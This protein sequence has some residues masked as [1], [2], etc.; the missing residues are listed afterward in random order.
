MRGEI[1]DNQNHSKQ[2]LSEKEKRRFDYFFLEALKL[3]QT[4][5]YSD[6]FNTFQYCLSIDSTSAAT[7]YELSFFYN[8]L[9]NKKL[10]L[11]AL[12]KA[13]Q[14]GGNR[15]DY[16]S[17]L[18]NLS[19]EMGL[20]EQAIEIYEQLRNQHPDKPEFNYFL[21]DLYVRQKQIDKAITE[22][23]RVEDNSGINESISI[24]KFRLYTMIEQDTNA[25]NEL[26]K[27]AAKYPYETRY[28]ILIG[29]LYLEKGENEKAYKAY[30]KAFSIDP[31][32]P[33][34]IVSMANYYELTGE[35]ALAEK[36]ID[37]A[38]KNSKLDIET[39][40]TILGRYIQ[41][42]HKNKKEIENAN[43]LI[44]TLMNQHPQETELNLMYGTF[45]L[46]QEKIDDAKFQFQ[47]VTESSP[48]NIAAW[49]QLLRI[50]FM[51]ENPENAIEICNAALI[52][53]PDAPQFYFYSGI[54]YYQIKD[55]PKALKSFQDG[56]QY[57][58][59][60]DV[61]LL[62]DFYGQIG[63]IYHQMKDKELSHQNYEKALEYN[64]KNISVLNNYAY[65]LALDKKDLGKAERMSRACV[66][67][68]PNNSTFIDTYAWIFFVQENY[69]LAKFYI[70]SAISNGGDSSEEII[71][72]Y[73]DILYKTGNVEKAVEQ[74]KKALELGKDTEIVKR[75]IA[76]ETYYE[77]PNEN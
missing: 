19:R 29:D 74:W 8:F 7:H 2:V 65:Y 66:N 3:K 13:V 21:S 38:L 18:A 58:E 49:E 63:D 5:K 75:K 76:D 4:G 36:E 51:E 22:L 35:Q 12:T 32:D 33:Y 9:H 71:D 77:A 68:Q 34:Y 11:D 39:K 41:N 14:H 43:A 23:D 31:E 37:T 40:L 45:L 67:M 53:F 20:N 10:A 24:Q 30:Q 17:A 46:A 64:D 26:E 60:D 16:Q 54:A 25:F 50:S 1:V 57:I 6:A 70:E 48:E 42:L 56:V 61:R 27:L 62:S 59:P 28:Q 55:Y 72:H 73:G 44:E 69:S 15:Y 52:H 47:I